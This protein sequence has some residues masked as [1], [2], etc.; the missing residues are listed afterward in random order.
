LWEVSLGRHLIGPLPD[1]RD[2][3]DTI[4]SV[5]RSQGIRQA[6]FTVHGTVTQITLGV[7]DPQQQ[8]Y[9][10]A[11]ESF[12]GEIVH[13]SGMISGDPAAPDVLARVAVADGAGN[14]IGGRLFSETLV[15]GAEID[16]QEWL[17]PPMNRQTDP[18][19]GLPVLTRNGAR[20][21]GAI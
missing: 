11:M 7:F 19:T 21:A 16:L 15:L 3:V 14:V 20:A 9:V 13:C 12:A 10:T 8:V 1:N 18:N 5:C 4:V 2:L 6:S 17:G